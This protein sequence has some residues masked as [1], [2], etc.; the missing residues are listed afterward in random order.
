MLL[1]LKFCCLRVPQELTADMSIPSFIRAVKRLVSRRGVSD[2]VISDNFKTFNSVEV[3]NY[4]AEH[5]VK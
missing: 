5:G 4:L 2:Q 1:K 3:K